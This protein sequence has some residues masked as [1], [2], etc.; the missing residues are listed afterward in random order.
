MQFYRS[1]L[2]AELTYKATLSGGPGGQHAN[3]AN[4]KIILE[5]DLEK[6]TLFSASTINQLKERLHSYLTKENVLQLTCAE[7]RS[8]H[9]NKK[10]VTERLLH[11]IQT[12]LTPPKKRKKPK[13]GKKF[14]KKRLKEKKRQA[15]K[16]ENRKNPLP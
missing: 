3:K 13:P 11:L 8:Q 15:E 4:T 12:N 16:K 7:T 5:W 2:I 14:H 1:K 10:I 6:T 9:T